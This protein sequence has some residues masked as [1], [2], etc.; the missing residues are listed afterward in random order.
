MV[1]IGGL[2]TNLRYSWLANGARLQIL[3]TET[4]QRVACW[5][6]GNVL[7]RNKRAYIRCVEELNNSF[8]K[9]TPLFIIGVNYE[10]GGGLLCVFDTRCNKIL[11]TIQLDYKV[12]IVKK[13]NC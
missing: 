2:T 3:N 4:S 7:T 6:W 5:V 12:R 8:G 13:Q 1:T 9:N 11:Q 10:N